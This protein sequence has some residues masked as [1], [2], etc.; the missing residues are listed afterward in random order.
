MYRDIE[1]EVVEVI[2]PCR[3]IYGSPLKLHCWWP[4]YFLKT[5]LQ[6]QQSDLN[7][8]NATFD[9]VQQIPQMPFIND[10]SSNDHGV[11]CGVAHRT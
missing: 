2:Q 7:F 4:K 8:R 3:E 10:N 9:Y 11:K 6:L 1:I 5:V